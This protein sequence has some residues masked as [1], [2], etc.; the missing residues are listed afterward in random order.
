MGRS[1][2]EYFNFLYAWQTFVAREISSPATIT[3]S[4]LKYNIFVLFCRGFHRFFISQP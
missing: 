2:E 4:R 3:A 1:V